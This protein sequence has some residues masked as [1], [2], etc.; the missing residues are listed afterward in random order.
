MRIYLWKTFV[1]GLIS[2]A[3]RA[4]DQLVFFS[5]SAYHTNYAVIS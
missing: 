5:D 2:Y 3:Q 4:T 1:L